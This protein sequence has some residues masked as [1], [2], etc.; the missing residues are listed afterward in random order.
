MFP[1]IFYY[2]FNQ[3]SFK[4]YFCLIFPLFGI[5]ILQNADY[6]AWWPLSE[7]LICTRHCIALC[8]L[9]LLE[10]GILPSILRSLQ[11][12]LEWPQHRPKIVCFDEFNFVFLSIQ[13]YK[14]L[15]TLVSCKYSFEIYFFRYGYPDRTYLTRV[16][17]ELTAKGIV[18]IFTARK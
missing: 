14:L 7:W 6:Y 2:S 8:L 3:Y 9:P 4:L 13:L 18:P 17:A 12:L 15:S 11:L 16:N 10:R 5:V 1:I